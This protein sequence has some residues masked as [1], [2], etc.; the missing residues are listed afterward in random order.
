MEEQERDTDANR[1][2][3][4]WYKLKTE[5]LET[6][7]EVIGEKPK[8]EMNPWFDDECRECIQKRND[9]H[10]QYIN[11]P[12]RQ[13]REEFEEQRRRTNK[14]GQKKKRMALKE[15][16]DRIQQEFAENNNKG[17]TKELRI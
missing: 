3:E 1:I 10:K 16:T 5:L 2:E 6:A 9:A 13:R 17:P 14:V 4:Y 12:T 8:K 15:E 11:R 7:R